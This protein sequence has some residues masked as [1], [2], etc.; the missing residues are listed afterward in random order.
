M[1]WAVS[2]KVHFLESRRHGGGRDVCGRIRAGEAWAVGELP[3]P[4]EMW[5]F[6]QQGLNDVKEA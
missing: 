4:R 3:R 2:S 1:V 6:Y 5:G